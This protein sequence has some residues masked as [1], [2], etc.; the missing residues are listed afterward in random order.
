MTV[1]TEE[2]N[3]YTIAQEIWEDWKKPNFAAIPYMRAMNVMVSPDER[4]LYDPGTEIVLRFL[5][6]CGT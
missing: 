4:Y 6:N 5:C 2:R 3:L 1:K